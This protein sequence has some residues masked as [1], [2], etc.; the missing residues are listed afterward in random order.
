MIHT[1]AR[2]QN[3]KQLRSFFPYFGRSD[4]FAEAFADSSGC[5]NVNA[6]VSANVRM[7]EQ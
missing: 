7:V 3:N 1:H 5:V 2:T 6:N 4:I